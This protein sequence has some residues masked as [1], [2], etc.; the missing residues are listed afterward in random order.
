[1]YKNTSNVL[2]RCLQ[3]AIAENRHF[4]MGTKITP[5]RRPVKCRHFEFLGQN[6]KGDLTVHNDQVASPVKLFFVGTCSIR[7]TLGI[8]TFYHQRNVTS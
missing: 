7:N 8:T 1:M 3:Q 6:L 2:K 4:R 5:F